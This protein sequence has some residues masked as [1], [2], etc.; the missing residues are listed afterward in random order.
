MTIASIT[1][2]FIMLLLV[3]RSIFTVVFLLATV[4]IELQVARESSHF[5]VT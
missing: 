3:Y 1:V 2:I 4:F 5:W